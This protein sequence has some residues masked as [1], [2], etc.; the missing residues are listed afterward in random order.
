MR[1][2]DRVELWTAALGHPAP[3]YEPGEQYMLPPLGQPG[4]QRPGR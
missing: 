2:L 1:D 4:P 3:E